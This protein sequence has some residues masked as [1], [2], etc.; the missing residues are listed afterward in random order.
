MQFGVFRWERDGMVKKQSSDIDKW[1]NN[2]LKLRSNDEKSPKDRKK[3]NIS[4]E[5]MIVHAKLRFFVVWR[6]LWFFFTIFL[7]S[8]QIFAKT[9]PTSWQTGHVSKENRRNSWSNRQSPPKQHTNIWK[10]VCQTRHHFSVTHSGP[11]IK[12]NDVNPLISIWLDFTHS[13]NGERFNKIQ[14]NWARSSLAANARV[15][16]HTDDQWTRIRRPARVAYFTLYYVHNVGYIIDQWNI[17]EMEYSS[18]FIIGFRSLSLPTRRNARTHT[19][20]YAE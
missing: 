16:W 14:M 8:A 19:R 3:H 7:K 18:Q 2:L 13:A 15:D 9:V 5:I 17:T 6:N 4:S 1:I 10:N 20:G 12:R 11:C